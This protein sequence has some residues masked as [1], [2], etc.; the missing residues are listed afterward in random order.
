MKGYA[1]LAVAVLVAGCA[2]SGVQVREDQLAEFQEGK[3]T[4]QEIVGKLGQPTGSTLMPDG[5][6]MITYTYVAVTSRPESF[7]PVV[8]PLVGGHDMRSNVVMLTFDRSGLLKT[9]MASSSQ[10]GTG[11]GMISGTSAVDRVEQQPRQAP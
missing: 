11:M 8:G 7:V 9:K 5:S 2:A 4:M 6:R 3:T 1:V 10:H